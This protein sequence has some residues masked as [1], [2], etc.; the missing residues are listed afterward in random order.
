MRIL[1]VGESVI[2]N[3]L[4]SHPSMGALSSLPEKHVGGP[5]PS[6]LILL[7]RLGLD[8]TLVTSI[9]KDAD[10]S[11]IKH[12]LKKEKIR[13]IAK[14][15]KQT[16]VHTIIVNAQNGQRKKQRGNIAHT[17][18]THITSHFLQQFDLIILD[19]HEKEAF[20][21]ILAKKKAATKLI[22]DTSTEISDVTLEMLKHATYPII[23][24]EALVKIDRKKSLS[25]CLKKLQRMCTKPVI[26]TAGELGSILFEGK[27]MEIIPSLSIRSIDTTG[28][29]DIYRGAFAFG[30]LQK[31]NIRECIQFAN[32]VGGL[33]CT[34]MGNVAAIPTKQEIEL[35]KN[36]I[37]QKKMVKRT[38]INNYFMGLL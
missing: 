31:W 25:V 13:L 21:E 23:P 18:I 28:A 34:R 33:Q 32:L 11:L 36:I 16:K 6:A 35:C 37:I 17:P 8:C 2:D 4:V 26:A 38:T 12:V 7:S 14:I 10:G 30:I 19:R 29:G 22:V 15:Q 5:V 3:V 27:K 24:I 1:G 9:G 20:H